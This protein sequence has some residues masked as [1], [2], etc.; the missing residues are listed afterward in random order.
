LR[1]FVS[2]LALMAL[3]AGPAAGQ[4]I[5]EPEIGVQAG[6]SRE[7]PAGTNR[8]D[9]LTFISVPGGNYLGALLGSN[10]LFAVVPIGA[11]LAVEP[12]LTAMQLNA[13]LTTARLG[14]RVNYAITRTLYAAAGGVLNY[15]SLNAPSHN[16][17]GLQVALGYRR[18]LTGDLN[19]RLEA[20]WVS[21]HGSDIFSPFNTYSLL[22]GVSASLRPAQPGRGPRGPTNALWTPQLGVA[23]GYTSA[24]RIGT[25]SF[26][27]IFLPGSTNDLTGFATALP[28]P[29]ALFAILPIGG[30]WA[31]EPS[32]DLHRISGN[33]VGITALTA[34]ARFDYAVHGGWYGG[35]G[36][37]LAY[38]NPSTG[39]S[40]SIL[41][42]TLAW[43]YR[44][45]LAGALG[46][47]F[48]TSY[49]MSAKNDNLGTPPI[50]TLGLMLGAMIALR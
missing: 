20:N 28:A 29:P 41:G 25:S 17:I 8:D 30:R 7:K 18:H 39:S 40:G 23:G 49:T 12:Q 26:G 45:H 32:F 1:Y 10:A 31:L 44:F 33:G 48:E 38:V 14:V 50:N 24:H 15:Q 13:V 46:G 43:G 5:W 16:Q 37:Q 3:S 19:G 4:R 22:A 27:G 2:I 35:A 11:R 6:Y 42:A 47:R 36:A 9:A 34:G 21:T